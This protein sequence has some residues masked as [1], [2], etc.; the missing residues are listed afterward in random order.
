MKNSNPCI[1][2]H[3]VE[4]RSISGKY[5]FSEQDNMAKISAFK[6]MYITRYVCISCGYSEEWIEKK[7]DLE[8][9]RKN[10]HQPIDFSNFV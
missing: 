9:L 8:Y 3:S 5:P 6:K 7:E 10:A 2:C 1:K 4:I